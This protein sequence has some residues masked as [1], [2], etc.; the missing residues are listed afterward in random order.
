ML[1]G[2]LCHAVIEEG[3]VAKSGGVD[4]GAESLGTL[5]EGVV[6]VLAEDPFILTSVGGRAIPTKMRWQAADCVVRAWQWIDES[7]LEP[8]LVESWARVDLLEGRARLSGRLDAVM[9]ARNGE[10]ILIDWKFP[11][12]PPL[13]TG[14]LPPE[15]GLPGTNHALATPHR[16]ALL[17]YAAGL[18]GTTVEPAYVATVSTWKRR[19]SDDEPKPS[20]VSL[21]PSRKAIAYVVEHFEEIARRIERGDVKPEPDRAG[22]SCSS[23][24]CYYWD[25]CPAGAARS[26]V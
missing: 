8:T 2:S 22:D 12:L 9:K 11:R 16:L 13:E 6:D 18:R 26:A 21:V 14:A 1:F 20:A 24:G 25:A 5:A 3:L 4:V 10:S 19:R 15:L 17:G 7:E 23:A